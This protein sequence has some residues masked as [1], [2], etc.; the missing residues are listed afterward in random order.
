MSE[1]GKPNKELRNGEP[2]EPWSQDEIKEQERD[3]TTPTD[4]QIGIKW[5]QLGR[6]RIPIGFKI[7]LGTGI[8]FRLPRQRGRNK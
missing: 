6:F 3:G 7:A 4:N 8:R 5:F 1:F 2:P